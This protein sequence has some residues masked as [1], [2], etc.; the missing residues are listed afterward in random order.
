M[1]EEE[2][3]MPGASRF[4]AAKTTTRMRST[5]MPGAGIMRMNE[6]NYSSLTMVSPLMAGGNEAS[7]K[8]KKAIS[9]PTTMATTAKPVGI[10]GGMGAVKAQPS[11]T[12]SM[13]AGGKYDEGAAAADDDGGDDA[14]RAEKYNRR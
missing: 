12:A 11:A 2:E 5:Q 10:N 9:R 3:K 1:E 6:T 13:T 7:K 4:E 14:E 8:K